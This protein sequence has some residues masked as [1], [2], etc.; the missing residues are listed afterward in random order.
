MGAEHRDGVLRDVFDVLDEA[1][2][3]LA[4]TVDN[5]LVVDDFVT[6]VDGRAI[7][8]ERSFD[9]VDGPDD[10]GTKSSRLCEQ[11]MQRLLCQLLSPDIDAM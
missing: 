3:L 8:L 2:T 7:D 11:D 10:S 6:N 4:Q 5:V 1:S 9:D